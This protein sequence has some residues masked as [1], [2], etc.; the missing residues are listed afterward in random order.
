[1]HRKGILMTLWVSASYKGVGERVSERFRATDVRCTEWVSEW[2]SQW[3][4]GWIRENHHMRT[5]YGSMSLKSNRLRIR[6]SDW[7]DEC[8]CVCV[9][10]SDES[11][12]EWLIELGVSY[13]IDTGITAAITR[14]LFWCHYDT[15]P[16]YM[17]LCNYHTLWYVC[18]PALSYTRLCCTI[19]RR[20]AT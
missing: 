2:V 16:F 8:V 1:M 3:V 4:G 6:S 14:L 13:S 17:L 20:I 7:M 19:P 18:G 9:C 11:G 15:A 10:P 12:I 5:L